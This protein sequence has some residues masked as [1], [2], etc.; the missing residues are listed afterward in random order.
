MSSKQKVERKT[1]EKNR[2]VLM[3]LL[4]FKMVSLIPDSYFVQ[5]K[6]F[7]SQQDQLDHSVAYIKILRDR[8]EELKRRKTQLTNIDTIMNY[9]NNNNNN[10][11]VV[12]SKVQPILTVKE[13]GSSVE[14]VVISGLIKNFRLHDVITIIQEEAAEVLTVSISTIDAKIIHTIHAQV[15]PT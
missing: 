10:N 8:L 5:A 12:E 2:R 15:I 4:C 6:E 11:N 7:L 13:L 9:T 14:V 3:K 1:V